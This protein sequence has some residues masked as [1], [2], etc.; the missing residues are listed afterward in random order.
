MLCFLYTAIYR[1]LDPI[2]DAFSIAQLTLRDIQYTDR[3]SH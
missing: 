2:P 3:L 1:E